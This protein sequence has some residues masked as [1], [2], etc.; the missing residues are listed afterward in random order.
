MGRGLRRARLAHGRPLGQG[1]CTHTHTLSLSLS[2]THT[3]THT[4]THSH[5]H[6]LTQVFGVGMSGDGKKV[7]S[8]SWD[9]SVRVWDVGTG[10]PAA[11]PMQPPSLLSRLTGSFK[12]GGSLREE[13]GGKGVMSLG[14]RIKAL[15]QS[16]EKS[17]TRKKAAQQGWPYAIGPG[18]FCA[19]FKTLYSRREFLIGPERM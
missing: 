3:H 11:K 15:T 2:R 13:D 19:G 7:V 6:T 4:H 9:M 12:R 18:R 14:E 10:K 17:D 8:C 1:F 5:T 16:S